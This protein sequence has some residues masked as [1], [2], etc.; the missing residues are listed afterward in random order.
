MLFQAGKLS[1]AEA[2]FRTA[3]AIR[4]KL[5]HDNP[6]AIQFRQGLGISH[7]SLGGVLQATGRPSEA[8]GEYRTALALLQKL[9]DDNPAVVEIRN[10]L[11]AFHG[12]LGELLRATGRPSEAEAEYRAALAIQKK[13]DDD[14]PTN[15][16]FCM[17][18]AITQNNLGLLLAR[19][20]RFPEA[21]TA[22]EASLTIRQKQVDADPKHIL[23]TNQLGYSYAYRG[24]ARVL[25]GQPARAATDLRR[26]RELWAK[27]PSSGPET[28][29][30]R[31]RVL[32]LLAGL[33]HDPKSGV[34]AAEAAAFADQ[35]VATLPD[36][37]SI[38]WAQYEELTN[39]EFD[40]LRG[41]DDFKKLVAELEK[42][43][44][45]KK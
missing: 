42:K 7:H 15:V 10:Q 9:A 26:A 29:F 43:A 37:I 38:G 18:L 12:S 4:Q 20:K 28:R 8:E 44:E 11:G 19:G 41:R 23:Y 21:F 30:E 33:G 14:N 22:L 6:A 3:L 35:A 27:L 31:S 2:E 34:T 16:V 40:A 24:R 36:A 25:A 13:V 17:T 32:A 1:E 39:P 5:V 45:P